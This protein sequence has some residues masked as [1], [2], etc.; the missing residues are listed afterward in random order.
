[1]EIAWNDYIER[2][3]AG[4]PQALARLYDE[5][6]HLIYSVAMRILGNQ[7]DAEEATLDVYSQVWRSAKDYDRGR[8][9]PSSWLIMLARSRSLDHRRR[10]TS[11]KEHEAPL[12]AAG[13]PRSDLEPPETTA[14]LAQAGA[15][16]RAAVEE[17]APDQ[18]QAIELSFFMGFTH[19]EL[20]EALGQPLG[21]VKTR[22]RLGLS[23]LRQ[24]LRSSGGMP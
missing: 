16:V 23:R 18:K 19:S 7:A 14:A 12:E 15:R 5:T 24:L 4:E 21:T 2:A 10:R 17:L 1:M 6:C 3:A 20:A 11:R 13:D 22:I 9:S 8:G